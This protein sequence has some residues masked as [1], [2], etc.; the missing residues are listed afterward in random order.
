MVS[1][2]AEFCP[3]GGGVGRRRLVI[4][5]GQLRPKYAQTATTTPGTAPDVAP[6]TWLL[7]WS[8]K[9]APAPALWVGMHARDGSACFANLLAALA[10]H[11]RLY[12]VG[13]QHQAMPGLG[14][15]PRPPACPTDTASR[16][17]KQLSLDGQSVRQSVTA[18]SPQ[19]A[20]KRSVV[21]P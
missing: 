17:G 19:T 4:A 8:A 3:T 11:V 7:F 12:D 1:C 15:L 18:P 20:R 2:L 6:V 21:A 9:R 14:V 5:A 16:A 13:L 10:L